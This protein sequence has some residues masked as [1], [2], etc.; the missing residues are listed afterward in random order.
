MLI[1]TNFFIVFLI[2]FY[3]LIISENKVI[4]VF[5]HYRHGAR[6]PSDLFEDDLDIIKEKWSS[7]KELTNV[8]I[9]QSYLLGHF[10][11]NK[12]PNLINYNKYN[13]KEIEVI[14]T[15]TNRTLMSARATLLGIF[16]NTIN[17]V[18]INENQNNISTPYYLLNEI[19][20][21][22]LNN[23]YIYPDNYPDE[24]PIFIIDIKDSFIQLE[25]IC[26]FMKDIR[27][28][29]KERKEIQDY[30]KI[31]NSTFGEQLLTIYDIKDDEN[32]YMDYENVNDLCIQMIVNMFDDRE[33][34]FLK[35]K[36]DLEHLYNE[37]K[38][39]FELKTK[40]VYGNDEEGLL[41]HLGSSILIRSILSY[42]ERIIEN[43]D[44][45]LNL[46]P[47][48][49]LLSSHDTAIANMMGLLNNLFNVPQFPP[50]YSS[51]YIFEL[52]EDE[53][54]NEY[55]INLLFNN[56][57]IKSIKYID[58]KNIIEK[59]SFSDEKIG[60]YCQ[61]S[62]EENGQQTNVITY[63]KNNIWK[64][65]IIIFSVI[66]ALIIIVIVYFLFKVKNQKQKLLS[67]EN[68][69]KS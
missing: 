57:T 31:F 19:K 24:V 23:N 4:F 21:Y 60:N 20:N 35:N 39:F 28:K 50:Y 64:I 42:M 3:L 58:F 52:I 1:K 38:K 68:S 17:K 30:I 15:L 40:Y 69:N 44:N 9:R 49:V 18:K 37:S 62:N 41:A 22:N 61:F 7:L 11:R 63:E 2:E 43:K 10:I 48:L 33:F 67:V 45:K 51:N 27:N 59:E 16:N 5:Q 36:I 54:K 46:S 6:S 14:S 32:Y 34:N 25:K 53:K 65:L 8:G 13:P 66:N 56:E 29:N 12:Y 26:P 55:S 47:K